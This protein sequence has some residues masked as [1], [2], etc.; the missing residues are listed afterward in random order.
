MPE[1]RYPRPKIR[2][3]TLF[4]SPATEEPAAVP[5]WWPN[6]KQFVLDFRPPVLA[7]PE[8]WS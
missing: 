1:F 4:C 2:V 7:D 6:G 8:V 3:A 5:A